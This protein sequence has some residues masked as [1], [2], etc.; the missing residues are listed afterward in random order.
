MDAIT[1]DRLL[2][3]RALGALEPDVEVLLDEYLSRHPAD[4]DR[5]AVT[6][7][8]VALSRKLLRTEERAALPDFRSFQEPASRR[9]GILVFRTVGIAASLLFCFLLGRYSDSSGPEA[10]RPPVVVHV[11]P[12]PEKDGGGGIWS[13]KRVAGGAR[14]VRPSRWEW[15]SPVRRPEFVEQGETM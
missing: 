11:D 7:E 3:D 1:L 13:L 15:V 8:T 4:A 5:L 6:G 12:A 10:V 9:R 14:P 2:I